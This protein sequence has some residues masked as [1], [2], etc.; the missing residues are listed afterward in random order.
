MAAVSRSTTFHRFTIY[1]SE[2]P[3]LLR[4]LTAARHAGAEPAWHFTRL[5]AGSGFKIELAVGGFTRLAA[6]SFSSRMR[7]T[8][9]V[10]KVMWNKSPCAALQAAE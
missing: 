5:G 10:T 8:P 9:G 1:Y 7:S 3:V 4:V 6:E 2:G